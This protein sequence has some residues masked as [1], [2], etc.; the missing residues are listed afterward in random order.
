MGKW[1]TQTAIGGTVIARDDLLLVSDQSQT[2]GSQDRNATRSALSLAVPK[3][4]VTESSHGLSVGDAVRFDGTN[5]VEAT[6]DTAANAELI[7][8]VVEVPDTDTLVFQQVGYATGLSGLTA[9]DYYYLQDAG[10]LGTTAGT[11]TVPV[12]LADSTTSG[13]LLPIAADTG[14]ASA[15][16]AIDD[17][18]DVDTST[19]AP[20]DGEVLRWNNSNSE[21]EPGQPERVEEVSS[22]TASSGTTETLDLSTASVFN[23]T[24]SD[25]CT[26]TFS[27]SPSD[28]FGFTL[29]LN[30]DGTG[31][32]TAT[33]PAAVE[34]AGGT[35][36]TL[37]TTASAT[38]ILTFVTD[39][40]GTTWYGFSA[41]LDFS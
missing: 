35:A 17:L 37:T 15:V 21:W 26:F 6:A 4:E 12:L 27:N 33:W 30:Q 1:D 22:T 23:V 32:R 38:D 25:N 14:G 34:W 7:G 36:P 16:S 19:S 40:G 39:D 2:N 8:L 10:G 20:A 18:S 41:G 11:V 3:Y 24:L 31:S 13:W 5:Y 28:S 29:I 9:G